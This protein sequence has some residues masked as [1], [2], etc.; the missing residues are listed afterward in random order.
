MYSETIEHI[1]AGCP[2]MAQTVYLDRHN[3]V[4]S[5]IHWCLCGLC[6]FSHSTQWWQH[7]PQAVLNNE[8]FKLL[9]DF[10]IFTDRRISARRPHVVYMDKSSS[11]T[12]LLN[13]ACIMDRNVINKI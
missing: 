8:N 1:I 11:C 10:N 4:T 3:A 12:K 6:G 9:Y 2:T 5:A 7:Q 13:V